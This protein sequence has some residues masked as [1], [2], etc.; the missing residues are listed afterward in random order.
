MSNFTYYFTIDTSNFTNYYFTIL[1]TRFNKD[2]NMLCIFSF[3]KKVTVNSVHPTY[4]I[5]N[6]L[7]LRA[8]LWSGILW[9]SLGITSLNCSQFKLFQDLLG[10]DIFSVTS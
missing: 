10:H 5:T 2:L 8:S 6:L 4:S 7:N 1:L 9:D 3:F